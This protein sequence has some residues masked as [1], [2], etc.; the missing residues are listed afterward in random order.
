MRK[1]AAV[2]A[3]LVTC[4]IVT[5][6]ASAATTPHPSWSTSTGWRE[7]FSDGFG[8]TSL[9]T[10]NWTPGWFGTGKTGPVNTEENAG[11]NS[12]NVS[13]S[14]G[15]LHLDLTKQSITTPNGT[16]P[17]TGA[18][19]DSSGKFDFAYGAIEF[20]A[21]LPPRSNGKPA[22]WPAL[23]TDGNGS[24]PT[25]GEMDVMEGLEGDTCYHFHDPSGGPGDCVSGTWS[26]WHKFGA[27]W[28]KG[29]VTF[30][31]DSR[32]VG[33]ITSG[34][35]SAP[36]YLILNNTVNK[37]DSATAPADMEVNWVRVWKAS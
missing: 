17:Y 19:I 9:K 11:Y 23:W 8:G 12:A 6:H 28:E 27:D 24:W 18:L 22:N 29:K 15:H 10:Q 34:I 37:D 1:I 33:E 20:D 21:Y 3:A 7:I 4:F 13:L 30:Y 26:G 5:P 35:T 32:K 31:Y 14:G 16:F 25:T 36:M 2:L